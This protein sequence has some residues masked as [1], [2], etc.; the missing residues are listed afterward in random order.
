MQVNSLNV[1]VCLLFI[2]LIAADPSNKWEQPADCSAARKNLP[3]YTELIK[4][5]QYDARTPAVDVVSN[6]D[7]GALRIQTIEFDIGSG[8]TCSAELIAP[9]RVA[10]KYPGVVWLGSGDKDWEPYALDFSKPG[11]V[12][13]LLNSCGKAPIVDARAFYKDLVQ[14]VINVRRARMWIGNGSLSWVTAEVRYGAPMRWR[15]TSDSR[16]RSRGRIAGVY[17]SHLHGSDSIRG[18]GTQ[19]TQ[20]STVE[21]GIPAC[22][23]RCDPL[24]RA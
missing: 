18:W 11:A 4:A 2:A 17:L 16:P 8:V 14:T 19:G 24:C 5:F 3:P 22:A 1:M 9:Y 13:I 6:V 10:E 15:S 20:E 23:S 7:E 12:S 21:L